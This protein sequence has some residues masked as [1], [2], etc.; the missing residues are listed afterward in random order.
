MQNNDIILSFIVPVYNVEEY[1]E[2][3][4]GSL[5]KQDIPCSEYEIIC[6]DDGSTDRSGEILDDYAEKY[7]HITVVHKDNGGVSSARN[8]GIDIAKGNYIWF[9]DGD[10]FIKHNSLSVVKALI[11]ENKYDII[12]VQ[13]LPYYSDEDAISFFTDAITTEMSQRDIQTLSWTKIFKKSCITDNKIYFETGISYTEDAVF[14]LQLNSFLK[15]GITV[16]EGVL[17]FYRQRPGS[18]MSQ[19]ITKK[20]SS[21]I[22]AAL[23]CEEIIQG[24]RAGDVESAHRFKYVSVVKIMGMIVKLNKSERKQIEKCLKKKNLF[25]LKFNT[26]YIPKIKKDKS[27]F[28]KKLRN[29]LIDISYTRLGY[30]LLCAYVAILN[31]LKMVKHSI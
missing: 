31:F 3:C 18:A 4:L 6:V 16:K 28:I 7:E 2:D 25:P 26:Q 10:D 29:V 19:N 12:K 13:I 5:V 21:R 8:C 27:K 30:F 20:I 14:M 22:N 17:Y 11:K 1:L 15:S 24:K 9:V 23:V